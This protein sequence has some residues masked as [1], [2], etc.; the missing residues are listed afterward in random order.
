MSTFLIQ[1][2][3]RGKK[4]EADF[5]P[6]NTLEILKCFIRP[7]QLYDEYVRLFFFTCKNCLASPVEGKQIKLIGREINASCS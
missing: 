1:E 7:L 5:G 2:S 6:S 3:S 4:L